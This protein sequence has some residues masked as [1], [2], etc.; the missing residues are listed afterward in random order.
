MI[1]LLQG[2]EYIFFKLVIKN[3][4]VVIVIFHRLVKRCF[5]EIDI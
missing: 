3:N 4:I 5:K 1:Y 2:L